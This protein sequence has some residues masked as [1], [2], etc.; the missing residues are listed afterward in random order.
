MLTGAAPSP[1]AFETIAD[2]IV[3]EARPLR[4]NAYKVELARRAIVRALLQAVAG[5][6]HRQTSETLE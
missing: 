1:A 4:D 3:S 2:M 5:A 6:P